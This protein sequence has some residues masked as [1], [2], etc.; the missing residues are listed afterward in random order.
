GTGCAACAAP[1]QGGDK[2][3]LANLLYCGETHGASRRGR[4]LAALQAA[5]PGLLQLDRLKER[6][7]VA[8][9][10]ALAAPPLDHLDEHGRAVLQG[11]REDL[12]QVA[13]VITVD[14]D[15]KLADSFQRLANVAYPFGE[16]VVVGIGHAQELN[17]VRLKLPDRLDDV[18]RQHG[19]VLHAGRE[20][21]VQV[22][23]DLALALALRRL[24]DGELDAPVA[25][26]HDLRH[27]GG[28]LGADVL[29]IK[30]DE[31]A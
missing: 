9:A 11:A 18:A 24:V 5:A 28:V 3:S 10:E 27:K 15:A 30:V 8:L 25:V 21:I 13:L 29:V 19:D 31:L 20:I 23:L 26:L 7:E 4:C 12:Q 2:R 14:E 16:H 17:A 22:L 1:L 6:L